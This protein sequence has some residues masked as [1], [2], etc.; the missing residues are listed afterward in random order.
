MIDFDLKEELLKICN[1]EKLSKQQKLYALMQYRL[2]KKVILSLSE[3]L[4]AEDL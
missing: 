2:D 1:N 4:C 3:I